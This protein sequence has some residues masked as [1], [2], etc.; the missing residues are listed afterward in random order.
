[1]L[2]VLIEHR[3]SAFVFAEAAGEDLR[4]RLRRLSPLARVEPAVICWRVKT[5]E[6]MALKLK[7]KSQYAD[8]FR[9]IINDFIGFRVLSEHSG[10]LAEFEEAIARWA[11][12]FELAKFEHEET[13]QHPRQGV[14]RAIHL[15]YV[16]SDPGRFAL[17]ALATV[18]V[19]LT[20]WLDRLI[21][22]LSHDLLYKAES[23]D[24]TL[25]YLMK[26]LA[27]SIDVADA[28]LAPLLIA[29]ERLLAARQTR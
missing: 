10:K 23:V 26:E 24:P 22:A 28:E 11:E 21:S 16:F 14:Y 5:A 12:H 19:Q 4:A 29:I 8:E 1:V 17:P 3:R 2:E 6:A 18:E 15:N 7:H 9:S 20:T 25:A 13:F 27:S